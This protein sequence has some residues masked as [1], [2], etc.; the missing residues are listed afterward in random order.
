M[1]VQTVAI[2]CFALFLSFAQV[3][4]AQSCA[5]LV[6]T[7][8]TVTSTA[9]LVFPSL[10]GPVVQIITTGPPFE[11]PINVTLT[12]PGFTIVSLSPLHIQFTVTDTNG[13]TYTADVTFGVGGTL[14]ISRIVK[15]VTYSLNPPQIQVT[16]VMFNHKPQ[17]LANDDGLDI[18]YDYQRSLRFQRPNPPPAGNLPAGNV[19]EWTL[20]P[21]NAEPALWVANKAVTIKARF[22]VNTNAV[23]SADLSAIAV[24]GF[25]PNV[26]TKTVNFVNGVSANPA[27]VEFNLSR[28]T[29]DFVNRVTDSWQWKATNLNG[30]GGVPVNINASGPHRL[31]TVLDTPTAPWYSGAPNQQPWVSALALAIVRAGTIGINDNPLCCHAAHYV[32]ARLLRADI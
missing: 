8:T 22:T 26:L 29:D 24:G 10:T 28:N 4:R 12:T 11:S 7:S 31:Y 3:I 21:A 1:R 14:T 2:A 9:T 17:T 18:R 5:T 20:A 25:I 30:C 15:T 27:Y 19:G 23:T 16:A 6:G 32:F 13:F